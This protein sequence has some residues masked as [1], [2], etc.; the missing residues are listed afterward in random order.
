MRAEASWPSQSFEKIATTI[1]FFES[2]DL[3][4]HGAKAMTEIGAPQQ[5]NQVLQ[6]S[7]GSNVHYF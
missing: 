2:M 7:H 1:E 5:L 3:L 4:C 6:I